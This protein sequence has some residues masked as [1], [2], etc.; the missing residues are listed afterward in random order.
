MN[1]SSL[2]VVHERDHHLDVRPVDACGGARR[3]PAPA[4]RRARDCRIPRRTPRVPS[5]G[6]SSCSASTRMRSGEPAGSSSGSGRNS[7]SG[8][9]SS[10][11]HTGRPAMAIRI[12]SKSLSCSGRR[13][14]IAACTLRVTVG[15]DDRR[16]Q[17][18]TFAEEHVLG[19]TQADALGAQL[20]RPRRVLTGVRVG[21][22]A[23]VTDVVSPFE[24]RLKALADP[25]LDE[26]ARHRA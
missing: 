2:L 17:R 8:G 13:C 1:S 18:L 22:H 21:A 7:L 25:G 11:T 26:R 16:H 14:S 6:L 20:D 10:R 12:A 5:I 4:S 15:Q 23:Q 24:D 19:A 3:A 9:S